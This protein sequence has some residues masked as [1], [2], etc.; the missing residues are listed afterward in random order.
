MKFRIL[1]ARKIR[2]LKDILI[3]QELHVIVPYPLEQVGRQAHGRLA[4]APLHGRAGAGLLR[5]RR[6][7]IKGVISFMY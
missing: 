5:G 3:M 1:Y 6:L 2:V 4:A 7:G